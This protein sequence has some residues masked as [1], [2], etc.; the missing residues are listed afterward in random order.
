M[1]DEPQPH[2]FTWT[3]GH[4][5]IRILVEFTPNWA[6]YEHLGV[7]SVEPARARLPIT[8]TG[9][10]SLFVPKGTVAAHGGPVEA[11]RRLLDE[12]AALP[13]WQKHLLAARQGSLF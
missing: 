13:E 12:A 7:K 10:K 4:L 11:V 9:Y 3:S 5:S 8:E 2:E 1:I 6:I